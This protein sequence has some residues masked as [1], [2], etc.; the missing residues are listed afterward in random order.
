MFYDLEDKKVKN[1]GENWS[2]SNAFIIETKFT[3]PLDSEN[4]LMKTYEYDQVNSKLHGQKI[5]PQKIG[6][7]KYPLY[8]KN[9]ARGG[10]GLFST[11]SDYSIFAKMLHTGQ[12]LTGRTILQEKTL[13]LMSKNA[14][15]DYFFPIEIPSIGMV[16]DENYVN[17][18]QAYGWGLG[19]RTLMD[20]SKNNHLGSAGEFGWAGAASTYFLVDNSKEMT[21]LVMTQV[22]N[23]SP[24]LKNDFYKF[25]YTNF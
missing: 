11:I 23:G 22:L 18:L 14:L 6:N 7:Y 13:N 16:R 21:A 19:C 15:E 1:L 8:E 5:E 20:P 4:R 9:Y 3:V 24:E 2:A 25:I 10:H 17:D 12:S